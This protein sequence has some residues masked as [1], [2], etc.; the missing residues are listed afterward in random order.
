MANQAKY[1][2]QIPTTDNL[3]NQL[4]DLATAG[5]HWLWQQTGVQGS[6]I[7]PGVKGNWEADPQEL[8]DDLQIFAED[9][10]KMDSFIKQLAKHL[11]EAGNQWGM[12]VM[13]EGGGHVQS[14]VIDNPKYV[15]G[16]PAPGAVDPLQNKLDPGMGYG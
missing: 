1:T 8:F 16:A 12:F 3:G 4:P 2:L 6:R 14:W 7:L 13:K 15:E 5:H 11:N 10:P 9:T